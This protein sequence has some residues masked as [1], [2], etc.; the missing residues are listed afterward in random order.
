MVMRWFR[1]LNYQQLCTANGLLQKA[2]I[3]QCDQQAKIS[4][5]I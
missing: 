3:E 5:V 1:R 4:D 2:T